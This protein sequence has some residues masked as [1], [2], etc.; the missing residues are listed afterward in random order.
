MALIIAAERYDF[1]IHTNKKIQSYWIQVR[2][3][4]LCGDSKIAQYAILRYKGS[5]LREPEGERLTYDRSLQLG[6]VNHRLIAIDL[7]F[8]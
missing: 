4:G 8:N 7:I 3:L 6:S 1:V 2:G 5:Q